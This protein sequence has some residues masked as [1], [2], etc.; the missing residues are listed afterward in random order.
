MKFFRLIYKTYISSIRL[1]FISIRLR[2]WA[3]NCKDPLKREFSIHLFQVNVMT[4]NMLK[5]SF[6]PE[7]KPLAELEA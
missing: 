6:Y 2:H 1:Y 5:P 3:L 7:I 4:Y